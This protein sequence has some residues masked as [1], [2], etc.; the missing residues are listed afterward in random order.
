MYA[1]E[2]ISYLKGLIDG[3]NL[4]DTPENEKFYK[5][6][7]DALESLATEIE[8]HENIHLDL[9]DYLEQLDEDVSL[10]EDDIDELLGNDD[11]YYED[12]DEY[13]YEDFNEEEYASVKCPFCEKDF[14]FEPALYEEDEDL[15]CPH[16][17]KGFKVPEP[18]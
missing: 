11:D 4:A 2:K 5:A 9:N 12:E 10:I 1:K 17:G 6:L 3:Q 15:I 13:D 14:Y 7:I 8:E 16:C 18:E